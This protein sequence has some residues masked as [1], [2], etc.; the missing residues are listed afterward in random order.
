MSIR[1][2]P[3]Y[4][5]D[6]AQIC[7]AADLVWGGSVLHPAGQAKKKILADGEEAWCLEP[8]VP[9]NT[10][11]TLTTDAVRTW[12]SLSASQQEAVKLVTALYQ[13]ADLSGTE[14]E[15]NVAAQLLIWEFVKG[16]RVSYGS[17]Q[18]V[19]DAFWNA[20]F[21]GGAN[22]G[23]RQAYEQLEALLADYPKTPSFMGTEWELDWDGSCY[24]AELTDRNDCLSGF[25][26]VSSDP[27]VSVSVSDN[28]L[29][30]T[31]N[32]PLSGAVT[33]TARKEL[34]QVSAASKL[35]A[36]GA[37]V[38]QEIAV[39][40]ERPEA[41]ETSMSVKTSVG[42][43]QITKTSEDG[44]VSGISFRITGA[45]V[46]RTVKTD[47]S[48][49]VLVANLPSG[50]YTVAEQTGESYA[51][52]EEQTVM[53]TDGQ[54]AQ[55]S[56]QNRLKKWRVT[57]TKVDGDTLYVKFAKSGQTKKLLKDYAP[58]VKIGA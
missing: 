15:Q 20:M 18:R 29:T 6:G 10:G 16:A 34:T 51:P 41:V 13:T 24:R 38:Y 31:A 40:V 22:A 36:Y 12:T 17:Y 33:I 23:T 44:A 55:V 25:N 11:T 48:G 35:V 8:G 7:Y 58:I 54:P 52:T 45:G 26:F 53:V 27:A 30:L 42:A 28:V 37:D 1:F 50:R 2:T 9:L 56:F 32:Q 14:G 57:V 46:D 5:S 49:K 47:G 21:T 3:N 4:D 39:G 19:D 43:M